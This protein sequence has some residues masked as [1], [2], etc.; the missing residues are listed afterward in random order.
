MT[1]ETAI[2]FMCAGISSRFGGK[3][4]QFARVGPSGESLIEYSLKQAISAGFGKIVFIVGKMTAEPFRSYFGEYFM[5]RKTFYAMQD[6]DSA[7]RDKPWGTSDALCSAGKFIDC[8]FVICNGDD[9]YGEENFKIMNNHLIEEKDC[10]SIGYKL[11]D[12]IPKNGRVNRAVFYADE[13]SYVKELKEIFDINKDNFAE[14]NLTEESLCS[15]NI[16]ALQPE[17]IFELTKVLNKFK[18]KNKSDR[19]IECLLPN[20]ISKLIEKKEIRMKIYSSRDRWLGVTNPEDEEIVRNKLK[21]L[22]AA[23]S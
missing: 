16:F 10:A 2:V 12:V 3:I 23:G 17:I 5:G 14:K 19:K 6:Y 18:E 1:K 8:P 7:N 21:E 9:I 13:K 4:K 11:I 22:N 20:E 15:M